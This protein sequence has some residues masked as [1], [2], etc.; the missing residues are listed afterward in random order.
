MNFFSKARK[1]T[2]DPDGNG[3][4]VIFRSSVAEGNRSIHIKNDQQTQVV[5]SFLHE[6]KNLHTTS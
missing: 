4:A 6:V 1:L 2:S 3:K 5:K